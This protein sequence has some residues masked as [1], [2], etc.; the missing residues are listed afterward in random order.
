MKTTLERIPGSRAVLDV[1]VPPE[2]MQADI[3]DAFRRL[4]RQVRVPGFRPGKAPAAV[5]ER[6]LGRPRV[7]KEAL[8]PMVTR[9]YQ[10]AV[11]EHH[12][13]PVDRPAI[14]VLLYEDGV[15]LHFVATVVVR[16]DVRLADW[17]EMHVAPEA[18]AVSAEAL[19]AALEDLRQARATWVPS[20]DPAVPGEMVILQ[21][22][23]RVDGGTLIDE[24]RVEGVLGEGRLRREIEEAVT[25]QAAGAVVDLQLSFPED[26][27]SRQLAGRTAHVQVKVLEVKRK[28]LPV[29]D[30]DFAAEV[31]Q[32]QTLEELRAELS[33]T[34]RQ[35]AELRAQ[36]AAV[37]LAVA[38]V[39]DGSELDLPDILVERAVDN[40]IADMDRRA[41]GAGDSLTAQLS[42]AGRTLE[43]LRAELRPGAERSVRTQ[44][45][46]D[47]VAE[48]HGLAPS[49]AEVDAEIAR[50]ARENRIDPATFREVA[51]Q[52]DNLAA[53]RAE[54][55]RGKAVRYLREMIVGPISDGG[56]EDAVQARIE[57]ASAEDGRQEPPAG[58]LPLPAAGKG[59]QS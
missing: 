2:E 54:L 59:M 41:Q 13:Y 51:L 29:L 49:E 22:S 47:A 50:L 25:G 15:P 8:D 31:S 24:R 18:V 36:Q 42:R 39:V 55:G 56:Q 45:V 17:S 6:M 1:E 5:L 58:D 53:L 9:A 48:Q 57:K 21:T 14:D 46:L 19:D 16:P 23:G 52:P 26:D 33:N 27:H 34:L 10:A 35:V 44:L 12:L 3:Q 37:D 30:D 40:L 11:A 4:A 32:R 7:L 38:Q 28:E 20:T 43:T